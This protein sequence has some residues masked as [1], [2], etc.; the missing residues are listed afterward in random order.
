MTARAAVNEIRHA[1]ADAVLF[2]FLPEATYFERQA[3]VS[4]RLYP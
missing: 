4:Q 3:A 2:C 1:V